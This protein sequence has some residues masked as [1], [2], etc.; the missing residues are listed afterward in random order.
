VELL[1]TVEIGD[2]LG[3]TRQGADRLTRT[4]EFP[5]PIAELAVGRVW[6]RSDV[7]AWGKAT[8]RLAAD[9]E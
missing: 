5:K 9:V 3:M 1:S 8:G 2:L 6:Q 4:A 7:V